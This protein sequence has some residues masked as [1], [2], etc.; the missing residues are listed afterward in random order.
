MGQ[1]DAIE[2]GIYVV[3]QT[4]APTRTSDLAVGSAASGVYVFVDQGVQYKDRAYVCTTDRGVDVVGTNELQFVQFSARSTAM[5]GNGLVTGT[6]EQLDVNVDGATLEVV[7]DVVQVKDA[8]ITNPKI[9]NNTIENIK[10]ANSQVT[11]GTARGLTAD[12][13]NTIALGGSTTIRP[14]FG[15]IPDLAADNNFTGTTNTFADVAVGGTLGVTG[16][17]TLSNSLTVTGT[18]TLQN[19][20][21]ATMFSTASDTLTV[22]APSTLNGALTVTGPTTVDDTL[23]VTGTTTLRDSQGATMLSTA[24]DTLTVSAPTVLNNTL[25]VA[26]VA[27]MENNLAVTGTS[28]LTGEATL[29]NALTVAGITNLN[30]PVTVNATLTVSGT[31]TLQGPTTVNDT[32]LV[33]G[34]TTL[35]DSQGATMLSTASDTLTVTAPSQLNGSLAVTGDASLQGITTVGPTTGSGAN[36]TSQVTGALVVNGGVGVSG[37]LFVSNTF[38]MSDERLKKNFQSL[39]DEALDRVK[40]MNA[41]RFEWNDHVLNTDRANQVSIGVKAQELQQLAPECVNSQHEFWAVDYAKLTPYLIEACKSL[42]ASLER[43]EVTINELKRRCEDLESGSVA[44]KPRVCVEE[45]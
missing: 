20:L 31:S 26:G 43:Q 21:G 37:D 23:L 29:G 38:N 27:T 8:G 6:A 4:G 22:T 18:T 10:L 34:T 44:K 33:T 24:S 42:N 12:G 15:V 2:N 36:S 40:R 7:A 25:N 17:T 5:A 9:M 45:A 35:R 39:S 41:Y 32:L 28:T 14:D 11:V 3:N 1:T 16:A 19:S 30:N 13:V